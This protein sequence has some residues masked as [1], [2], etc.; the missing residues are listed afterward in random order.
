MRPD[1]FF[2]TAIICAGCGEHNLAKMAIQKSM[3][4]TLEAVPPLRGTTSCRPALSGPP[5]LWWR[6]H[7][8]SD[9]R[10]LWKLPP[11]FPGCDDAP[12]S[13][14]GAADAD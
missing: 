11:L 3:R 5:R 14:V 9:P 8:S 6:R 4:L 12:I 2:A 1:P 13:P 7:D 10:I